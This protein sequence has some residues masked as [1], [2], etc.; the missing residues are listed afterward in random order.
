MAKK[1]FSVCF[2]WQGNEARL[3]AGTMLLLPDLNATVAQGG[4]CIV[5]KKVSGD[6][7]LIE[8]SGNTVVVS[9][10][11]P[12]HF[13]RALSL[14]AQHIDDTA[15]KAEEVCYFTTNG[16][17]FDVSQSNTLMTVEH[18]HDSGARQAFAAPYGADGAEY[19]DAL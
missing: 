8:R 10:A 2:D 3:Q 19:D 1:G 18:A 9:F 16:T 15:Y 17:M 4:L 7:L 12:I 6:R 11:Q 5:A 14:I 13:F